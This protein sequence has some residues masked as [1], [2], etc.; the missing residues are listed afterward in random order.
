MVLARSTHGLWLANAVKLIAPRYFAGRNAIL[1]GTVR[2]SA[3]LLHREVTPPFGEIT[4]ADDSH[5]GKM[6]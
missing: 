3:K 4:F 5:D 1:A 2:M 6:V